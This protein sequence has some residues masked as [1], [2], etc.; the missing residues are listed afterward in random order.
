MPRVARL[1]ADEL[2]ARQQDLPQAVKAGPNPSE[3]ICA[4]NRLTARAVAK[5]QMAHAAIACRRSGATAA[6]M[7]KPRGLDGSCVGRADRTG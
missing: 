4:T 6:V 1:L 7:G 3:A 2:S 5:T